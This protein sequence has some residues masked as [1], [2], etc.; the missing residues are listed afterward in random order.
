MH[1]VFHSPLIAATA[2]LHRR[3]GSRSPR[4]AAAMMRSAIISRTRF[5]RLPRIIRKVT[6][7]SAPQTKL[8]SLDTQRNLE[9]LVSIGIRRK[10]HENGEKDHLRKPA[11]EGKAAAEAKGW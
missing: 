6:L 9:H 11:K 2:M 10:V 8:K 3:S 4:L 1:L 5:D 7:R